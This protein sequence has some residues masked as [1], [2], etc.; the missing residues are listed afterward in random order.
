VERLN[1]VRGEPKTIVDLRREWSRQRRLEDH[2]RK[3]QVIALDLSFE[4]LQAANRH[5]KL[6][7]NSTGYRRRR[8]AAVLADRSVDWC[9]SNLMLPGAIHP[10]ACCEVQR[11]LKPQGLFSF[12]TLVGYLIELRRAVGVS[13]SGSHV[14]RFLDMHDLGD[15]L[16]RSACRTCD[17]HRAN[18]GHLFG[19]TGS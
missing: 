11:I 2:Y 19:F 12:T 10:I 6:F 17:G 9:I 13:R 16:L 8:I 15:A 4:M 5:R 3:A 18:H 1:L 7:R 14:H